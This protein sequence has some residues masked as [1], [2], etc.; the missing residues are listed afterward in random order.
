MHVEYVKE[1]KIFIY[2]TVTV[3][4]DD[5]MKYGYNVLKEVRICIIYIYMIKN[6]PY[7][8][9]NQTKVLDDYK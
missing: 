6:H 3:E 5:V 8:E 1:C 9:I 7:N 2:N 4:D